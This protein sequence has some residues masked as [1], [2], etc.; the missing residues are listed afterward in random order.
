MAASF[1]SQNA[2]IST[3]GMKDSLLSAYVPREP[4]PTTPTRIRFNLGATK[5]LIAPLP[6]IFIPFT[7]PPAITAMAAK[8]APVRK[9]LLL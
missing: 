1:M 6:P 9:S 3:P 2:V 7:H 5:L 8:L 4:T